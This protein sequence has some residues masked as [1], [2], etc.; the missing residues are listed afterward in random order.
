MEGLARLNE[1]RITWDNHE[2]L[3]VLTTA[4]SLIISYKKLEDANPDHQVL[5]QFYKPFGA[6]GIQLEMELNDQVKRNRKNI[7][8]SLVFLPDGTINFQ[9]S[10]D[11]FLFERIASCSENNQISERIE[12]LS[13]KFENG[14]EINIGRRRGD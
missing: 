12:R 6:E 11:H 7:N 9:K 2:K 1:N 13:E 10:P 8:K 14:Y 5:K 3:N 4:D